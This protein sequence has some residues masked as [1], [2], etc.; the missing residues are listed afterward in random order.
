[1]KREDVLLVTVFLLFVHGYL[2]G[3]VFSGVLGYLILVYLAYLRMEFNPLIRLSKNVESRMYEGKGYLVRILVENLTENRYLVGVERVDPF[4]WEKPKDVILDRKAETAYRI[5]PRRGT[6]DLVTI[7]RVKDLGEL[8]YEDF[9][10]RRKVEVYPSVDSIA[11]DVKENENV[12]LSHSLSRLLGIQSV[13]IDSLREYQWG[14][15]LRYVD[16]KATARL[17][18]LIVKNFL[19]EFEGGIYIVLD[20]CRDMR[21]AV[22]KSKI[23]YATTLALQIAFALKKVGL[24]V[25]DDYGVV[26]FLEPTDDKSKIVK[27]LKIAPIRTKLLP[28][29]VRIDNISGEGL[30][31]FRKIVPF[32]KRRVGF[33]DGLMEAFG[34]LNKDAFLIFIADLTHHTSELLS[35]LTRLRHRAILITPNPVLFHE[36]PK[37]KE[38]LLLLYRR[39]IEREEILKKFRRIIPTID[40]GPSDLWEVIRGELK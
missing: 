33:S 20:C 23:D 10:V 31:F 28:L 12:R 9:E 3:N 5:I 38:K 39:Y 19:R 35:V 15:S 1:M 8:Y 7:V 13:D 18:D 11:R 16:W 32:L 6:F 34:R 22:S 4:R 26:E 21:K 29:K 30:K 24:I 17:G 14:D 2:F 37:D 40:V 25:Y 36:I 27:A